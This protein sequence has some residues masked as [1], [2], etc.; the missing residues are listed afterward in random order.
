MNKTPF[1]VLFILAN[2]ISVFAQTSE[3]TRNVMI[4]EVWY[5]VKLRNSNTEL[6]TVRYEANLIS[7]IG[8]TG[9][10][11]SLFHPIDTRRY[12]LNISSVVERTV[13]IKQGNELLIDHDSDKEYEIDSRSETYQNFRMFAQHDRKD[14]IEQFTQKQGALLENDLR[15]KLD[16]TIADDESSLINMIRDKYNAIEV[17]KIRR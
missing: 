12:N 4:K 9:D 17:K 7:S 2:I 6:L 16:K 5:E 13:M 15:T 11:A 3:S 8:V 10:S 1:C 14:Q